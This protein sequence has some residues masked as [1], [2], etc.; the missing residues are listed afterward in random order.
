MYIFKR[1]IHDRQQRKLRAPSTEK[2]TGG[3]KAWCKFD[4]ELDG[5]LWANKRIWSGSGCN[6]RNGAHMSYNFQMAILRSHEVH[7]GRVPGEGTTAASAAATSAAAATCNAITMVGRGMNYEG[8]WLKALLAHVQ[9]K[10]FTDDGISKTPP[11][12]PA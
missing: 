3:L 5:C 7:R 2:S 4:V 6:K 10:M 8:L 1:L 11:D 9:A 12:R